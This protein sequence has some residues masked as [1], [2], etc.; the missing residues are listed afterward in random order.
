MSREAQRT[1]I[2][3][4][5]GS[6]GGIIS[7]QGLGSRSAQRG[8]C[9]Q[10]WPPCQVI[11]QL[12]LSYLTHEEGYLRFM[13][14]QLFYTVTICSCLAGLESLLEKTTG[15]TFT[16]ATSNTRGGRCSTAGGRNPTEYMDRWK[17]T[18]NAFV[19]R[20][21]LFFSSSVLQEPCYKNILTLKTCFISLW[22]MTLSVKIS[23]RTKAIT[24]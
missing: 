16:Y 21:H 24:E 14:F 22:T 20:D 10:S 17:F 4:F 18:R 12:P 11:Q 7:Q 5:S 1:R 6:S 15:T 19:I 8:I 3:L 23:F 13:F 9:L 2:T